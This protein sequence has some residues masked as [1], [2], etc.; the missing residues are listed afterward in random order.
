MHRTIEWSLFILGILGSLFSGYLSAVKF[1]TENCAFN[2]GCPYFLGYPACYF[3]F[4]MFFTTMVSAGLHVFH[5]V[6]GKK[7]NEVVYAVSILGILFA[8]YYTF[9]ELPVLFEEGI[10]AYILGLP[11]CALGLVFYIAVF[12]LAQRLKRDFVA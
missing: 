10:G 12:S 3:G 9:L 1:F 6:D 8:G 4:L 7:A 11:T 2:E 5:I